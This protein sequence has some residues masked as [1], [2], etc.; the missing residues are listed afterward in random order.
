MIGFFPSLAF[1]EL[2]YQI[3]GDAAH[4]L[5]QGLLSGEPVDQLQHYRGRT[6][7]IEY[8][9]CCLGDH[10]IND[11]RGDGHGC[12]FVVRYDPKELKVENVEGV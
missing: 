9:L 12:T 3:C 7:A 4:V 10:S 6:V 11:L 5:M 1:L 8:L 2:A